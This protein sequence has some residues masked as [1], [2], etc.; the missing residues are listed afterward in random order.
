MCSVS[1]AGHLSLC[2][3]T[4]VHGVSFDALPLHGT[5]VRHVPPRRAT[6]LQHLEAAGGSFLPSL[7]HCSLPVGL[8]ASQELAVILNLSELVDSL[9]PKSVKASFEAIDFKL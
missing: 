3:L 1:D 9:P 7:L 4:G 5:L 6:K 8:L 2:M